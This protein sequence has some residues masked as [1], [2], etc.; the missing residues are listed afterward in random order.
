M[1]LSEISDVV[2]LHADKFRPIGSIQ[3][4]WSEIFSYVCLVMDERVTWERV[5]VYSW[6]FVRRG[7]VFH[8]SKNITNTSDICTSYWQRYILLHLPSS[9]IILTYIGSRFFKILIDLDS[10]VSISRQTKLLNQSC[11]IIGNQ[12]FS[13]STLHNNLR[14]GLRCTVNPLSGE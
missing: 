10:T 13:E 5:D 4:R 12:N 3:G 2:L 6:H 11:Q 14:W 9:S 7:T 8:P 1:A